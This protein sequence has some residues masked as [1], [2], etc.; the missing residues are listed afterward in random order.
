[1]S[2]HLLKV[3]LIRNI[4][5]NNTFFSK[6]RLFIDAVSEKNALEAVVICPPRSPHDCLSLTWPN[7]G[8]LT[9]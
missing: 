5:E 2:V 6:E 7:G 9:L 4:K 3:V 1:M 8:T